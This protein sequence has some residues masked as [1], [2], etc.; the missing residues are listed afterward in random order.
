MAAAPEPVN[1]GAA[2]HGERSAAQDRDDDDE[3]RAD[4]HR[5]REG[6]DSLDDDSLDDAGL[7][8]D[9]LDGD[10]LDGDSLD[11]EGADGDRVRHRGIPTWDETIGHII[12][13]NMEAR[14]KNPNHGHRNRGPR[15]R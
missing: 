8:G 11:G 7:E 9:G 13:T 6:D 3:F 4:A 15:T 10:G 1:P 14:A 2:P 12:T 5:D